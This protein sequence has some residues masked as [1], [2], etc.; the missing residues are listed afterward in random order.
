MHESQLARSLLHAV[1]SRAALERARR[2][3][4]VRGRIA[5]SEAIAKESVALSFAALARG[6]PAEGARL[7]LSVVHLEARCR[8]CQARYRP[9]HHLLL[10]ASCGSPDGE[11]SGPAGLWI[12]SM[13]IEP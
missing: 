8:A 12:D 10:C 11:L 13:D 6:T 2:V 1:L 9:E 4:S 3:V 7:L 5:E